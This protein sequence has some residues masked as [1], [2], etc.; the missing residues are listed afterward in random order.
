MLTLCL[1]PGFSLMAPHIALHVKVPSL[2]VDG[3]PH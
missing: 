3:L 2:L 1:W